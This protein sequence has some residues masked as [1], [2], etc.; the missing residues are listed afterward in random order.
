MFDERDPAIRKMLL[1]AI[2]AGQKHNKYIGI[3]GQ[4][5]S[6]YPDFAAWLVEEG[7][8]SLSLNP[9]TIIE[10]WL[11]IARRQKDQRKA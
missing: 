8:S 7:I 9:D 6:D 1:M 2:K 3:C 5:P 11:D 4:G 10:T